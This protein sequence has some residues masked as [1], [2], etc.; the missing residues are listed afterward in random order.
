L[1]PNPLV[2]VRLVKLVPPFVETLNPP[3]VAA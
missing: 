1:L 2:V 3:F